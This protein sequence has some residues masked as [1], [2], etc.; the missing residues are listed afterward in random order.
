[1]E[2]IYK[3]TSPSGKCYIGRA[4][5]F[6]SRMNEHKYVSEHNGSYTIHSAIRKYGWDNFEK[7]IIAE[8][9]K[10]ESSELERFFIEK[11][12]SVKIGYNDTYNTESGGNMWEGLYDSDKYKVF[13]E[14]MSNMTKGKKNGMY[15]KKQKPESIKKMK[16]KAKG[17]FSLDWFIDRYGDEEGTDRYNKRCKA[18]SERNMKRNDVGKFIKIK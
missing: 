11:Y 1:M 14:K 9:K 13:V 3:L 18:L 12:D 15:G 5:D 4:R 8:V 16:E 10:E 7:E 2:V 17:R 6:D